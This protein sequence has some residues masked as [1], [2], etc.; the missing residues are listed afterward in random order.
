MKTFSLSSFQPLIWQSPNQNGQAVFVQ[1]CS[2]TKDSFREL[3]AV[4][5][6]HLLLRLHV[7]GTVGD[8]HMAFRPILLYGV[9]PKPASWGKAKRSSKYGCG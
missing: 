6:R 5:C 4:L 1:V 9:D 2:N 3:A 7:A 8:C